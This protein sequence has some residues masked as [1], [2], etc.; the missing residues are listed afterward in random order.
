[1]ASN[2]SNKADRVF[3]QNGRRL[4]RRR[5]SAVEVRLGIVAIIVL[6]AIFGWVAW[7]GAH[8]DPNLFAL[9]TDLAQP[10]AAAA[11]DRGPV[12]AGLAAEGWSEGRLSQFDYDNLYVKINGREGY[13]KSFGFERLYFL[14]I[15]KTDDPQTAVDIE[16][17]DLGT[18]ANAIG[19]YSGERS[20]DVTP[21]ASDAGMAH[22][23]RNALFMARGHF[24]LR[25]IGSAESPEVIALLKNLRDRFDTELPAEEVPWGFALFVG[26]M[27]I[28]PGA[29]SFA[30]ENAFS[31]G[32]ARNVY[33]VRLDDDAELFVTPAGSD[34]GARELAGRFKDGFRQYGSEEGEFIKDKYLDTYATVATSGP[35]VVGIHRATDKSE[36]EEAVT[37]LADVVRDLPLPTES[38]EPPAS[39]NVEEEYDADAY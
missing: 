24:Y 12:P 1:M 32:F 35:W 22:L 21:E 29:I 37:G 25:A 2:A 39:E 19:A 36:A 28:E 34:A 16:L 15:T 10:A 26:R 20:P 13:Y 33:S 3:V 7:K 30:P 38:A 11:M 6:A 14:S 17:Y 5:F 9:D 23:E 27:G 8:P 31:F 18:A 4:Y